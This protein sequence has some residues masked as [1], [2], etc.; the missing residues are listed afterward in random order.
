VGV[1]LV[2]LAVRS[3]PTVRGKFDAACSSRLLMCFS[4]TQ[5]G[6]AVWLVDASARLVC[7]LLWQLY[8]GTGHVPLSVY[9]A[10]PN[11]LLS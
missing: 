10:P 9:V 3:A 6:L 8:R 4:K 7:V 11:A 1:A 2:G 5:R